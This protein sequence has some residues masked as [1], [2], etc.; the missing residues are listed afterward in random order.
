MTLLAVRCLRG[1]VWLGRSEGAGEDGAG[2]RVPLR[3]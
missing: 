1:P 3:V 2:S